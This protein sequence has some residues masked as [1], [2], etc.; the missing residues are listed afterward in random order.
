MTGTLYID[1]ADVFETFGV[2]VADGGYAG[3][4]QFPPLKTP[5]QNY[6]AEEDGIEVDL[7]NPLLDS[8]TFTMQFAMRSAAPDYSGFVEMLADGAYHD[9]DF[10]EAGCTRRLRMT[11]APNLQTVQWLGLFTLEFADDFPLSGYAYQL[12]TTAVVSTRD[13]E[14]DGR[15]LA[16]YGVQV[17]DGTLDEILRA[18]ATK[19]NL[20]QNTKAITG[21]VY[22]GEN[23]TFKERD[24]KLNCVLRSATLAEFWQ[25]WNALLFDLARAGEHSLYA[26]AIYEEYPCYYKSCSVKIFTQSGGVVWY[27]F[28]ITLC[29]TS[30]RPSATHYVLG[31]EDG[32]LIGTEDG[33]AIETRKF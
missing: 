19:Q 25:N 7:T 21:A 31:A 2:F 30:G 24:I 22:D 26:A 32:G 10:R 5:D 33:A 11:Q 29:I 4:A 18:P 13:Y 17:T 28:T 14:L 3:L 6:W 15:A 16:D 23:M 12:P 8:K 1:G 27:D 9:F 20:L